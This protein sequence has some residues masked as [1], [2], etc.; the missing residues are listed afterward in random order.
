M[1]CHHE[2]ATIMERT[3]DLT[4]VQPGDIS[5][6]STVE[7][8]KE[9]YEQYFSELV[10]LER[11]EEM[12][13]HEQEIKK[14]SGKER[15]KRGR[16]ILNSSARD[17]GT[18]Y[19]GTFLVKFVRKQGMPDTE[20]SVGDLVR[21][22]KHDPLSDQNPYGTVIEKTGYS[23]LVSFN[24]K[25]PK[26][27]FNKRVRLDLYVNDVTFKRMLQAIK[28]VVHD[29]VKNTHLTA[30]LLSKTKSSIEKDESEIF[31]FFNTELNQSQKETVKNCLSSSL[32]HLIHGPPGTGKTITC[33]EVIEQAIE[34]NETVIAC[35]DSNTAVDNLVEKLV[36][37]KRRVVRIGHPARVNPLLRK[38]SLDYL[39]EQNDTFQKAQQIRQKAYDLKEK[40]DQFTFPSGRWRRGLSNG[41]IKQLASKNIGSR[42]ISSTTIKEMAISIEYQDKINELF[43]EIDALENQAVQD[44]INSAEVVCST[45]SSAGSEVLANHRFDL[46]VI[47]EATQSCEPSCLIP[48]VKADKVIMAGDHKQ[49]PPTILNEKAEQ[50]GFSISLFERIIALYGEKIK[51]LLTVQYRMNEKIMGFSNQQFYDKRLKADDS[52]K[53]HTLQ[54]LFSDSV[55]EIH[56][57]LKPFE[58][59]DPDE[60]LIWIDTKKNNLGERSRFGSSSKENLAEAKLIKKIV[61]HFIKL[62]IDSIDIGVITPY[63]DQKKL[64]HSLIDSEYLEVDTVDGFQ[65][66]EKELVLVSLT[67]SNQKGN[68]GFLKDLRRLNV[69]ITRARRKLV[70]VGD[71]QTVCTNKTYES[72]YNFVSQ[73]GI[74]IPSEQVEKISDT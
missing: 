34:N 30:S 10:Q 74:I 19:G 7:F 63:Y 66:R 22:S 68:I 69:S 65:G 57:D 70:I 36:K 62:G 23:L 50:K 21:I 41:Q 38:H 14:L 47:D 60:P 29:Q 17:D 24:E 58:I 31:S 15:E 27:V 35:A 44:L 53:H 61:N 28:Y 71:S 72:F 55:G 37:Q 33:V 1:I 9:T 48:I 16:A 43:I 13:R 52:V 6:I 42:G 3:D 5:T 40:Q 51:S 20:I 8:D 25:P 64:L 46:C 73:N 32:F 59:C 39:L 45:N 54:E 4:I 12:R 18:G 26:W 2:K 11:N 56:L 49:L 67:R